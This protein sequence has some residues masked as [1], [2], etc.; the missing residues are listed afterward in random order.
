METNGEM[1]QCQPRR[2]DTICLSSHSAI[3][4]L[5]WGVCTAGVLCVCVCMCLNENSS[6][7]YIRT[8]HHLLC[9]V[10]LGSI[11]KSCYFSCLQ[12]SLMTA[13]GMKQWFSKAVT[14][15]S[16]CGQTAPSLPREREPAW[17]NRSS[18]NWKQVVRTHMSG[19]LWSSWH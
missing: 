7:N 4:F 12:W 9:A 13:W 18:L 8:C 15:C 16:A 17:M 10:L 11:L 2:N 14:L 5:Y 1:Y 19:R 3:Y 6:F